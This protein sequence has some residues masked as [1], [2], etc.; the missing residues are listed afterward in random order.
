MSRAVRLWRGAAGA[1]VLIAVCAFPSTSASASCSTGQFRAGDLAL[2]KNDDG[3]KGRILLPNSSSDIP[4][5]S[6]SAGDATF[7]DIYLYDSS[8][9]GFVQLGWYAGNPGSIPYYAKPHLVYGES[10]GPSSEVLTDSYGFDWGTYHYFKIIRNDDGEWDIYV[11]GDYTST[12]SGSHTSLDDAGFNGEVDNNNV[13]MDAFA[14][15]TSYPYETLQYRGK[16]GGVWHY[17]NDHDSASTGFHSTQLN[18][19]STDYAYGGHDC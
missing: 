14:T 1:I 3:V 5:I 10:T 11:D 7:A 6:T 17:F 18:G 15:A 2:D 4:G 9:Y 16:T 19:D 12:F 8:G 13:K